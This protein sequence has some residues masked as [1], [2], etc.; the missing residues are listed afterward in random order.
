M[1]QTPP[2]SCPP[3]C[4]Y[5]VDLLG[6]S[7]PLFVLGSWLYVET[8]FY[9]PGSP[10]RTAMGS[11]P[12]TFPSPSWLLQLSA[13]CAWAGRAL[14]PFRSPR[15]AVPPWPSLSLAP[16]PGGCL[17]AQGL[18]AT[19]DGRRASPEMKAPTAVT[20]L[21]PRVASKWVLFI[22]GFQKNNLKM[23]IGA[24]SAVLLLS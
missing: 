15:A 1:F 10:R 20:G 7:P 9:L 17:P 19:R 21:A 12:P 18:A 3:P 13:V 5:R 22:N 24:C 4:T 16:V 6:S 8:S 14:A 23:S 11:Q 2:R